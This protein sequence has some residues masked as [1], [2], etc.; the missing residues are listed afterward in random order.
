MIDATKTFIRPPIDRTDYKRW[1]NDL[2]A[3]AGLEPT[4]CTNAQAMEYIRNLD[5][6]ENRLV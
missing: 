4:D 6:F 3:L 5:D 1:W 2:R